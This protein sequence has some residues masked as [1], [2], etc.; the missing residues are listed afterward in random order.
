MIA[1]LDFAPHHIFRK[2]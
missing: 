2:I 1:L